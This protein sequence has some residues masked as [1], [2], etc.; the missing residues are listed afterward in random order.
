MSRITSKKFVNQN[1]I[2]LILSLLGFITIMFVDKKYLHIHNFEYGIP[3][4][5]STYLV[6]TF[7][8]FICVAIVFYALSNLRNRKDKDYKVLF[9]YSKFLD[10]WG[11]ITVSL[12]SF[13]FICLL[14][15]A[16]IHF[17]NYHKK[18]I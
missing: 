10:K 17:M 14:I 11:I 7:F 1:I 12:F 18:I 16:H 4:F 5:N 6:R 2:L 13:I 3:N 15:L 9:N 8:I